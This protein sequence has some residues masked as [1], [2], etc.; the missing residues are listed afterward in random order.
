VGLFPII[1]RFGHKER[2]VSVGPPTAHDS[3]HSHKVAE[4]A[5]GPGLQRS[6]YLLSWFYIE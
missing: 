1:A 5:I 4:D 3:A 2:F 6:V